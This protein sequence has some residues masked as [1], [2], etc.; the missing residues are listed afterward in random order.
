MA[1]VRF[2]QVSKTYPPRR[3]SDPVEV[4]RQLDLQIQ[5]G[6]FLVLVGPSGCG[7]S[8][9]LRLLAGLEQPS[10]G[11]IYVGNRP[12]SQLRPAQRDVAMV[13]QSYALYPHLTV[14]GNIGFGLRRSR[15]R[16]A[17][18]QLQDS[19][20]LASRR[21]PGP[22]Q[23]RSRRE[24]RIAQRIAEVAETLELD[25]LLDRLPKE[26][27]G[28][29]K[30]RVALGRAIARQPA[31]FLMDEPLSN[32]DA[33]LRTGTRTQIV[34]LQRRL[35]TTTLYVTHDQVEAMTMGHRIAVLN[36]G[37]LQQLGT[38]MELYQWPANL[39]VAQFIGSP[40]MNLL[41]VEAIGA[42]QL[43]LGSRKLAV[44]GPLAEVLAARA[45]QEL[46]GGLRPE[47]FR[48]AP[49]TNRNLRAEVSHGEALGNEQLLTCRLEE[50][51]HLVQ[52]RVGPEDNLPPGSTLHLDV[53][54][55]GWR[56][57]DAAG[58]ALPLIA[59]PATAEPRLPS[60][61]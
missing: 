10:H 52:V 42:G 27:S 55:R 24:E 13:F 46:T 44:E 34:E 56:L 49:A 12:V 25:H 11:E 2:E 8:T 61:G 37:R 32:L 59:Q 41:P 43:Q 6:E 40:A 4:L 5:D 48:L 47:H 14:G 35:G 39:F 38:P 29:Q 21:L 19:L 54:P 58:D 60:F 36:A 53:D 16:T 57:F 17:L 33:K 30:Q 3:G 50:G 51:D 28:G 22:L 45:G 7:K 23:V 31:V 20:H 26:L 9:L 18:Q 15:H 1:E